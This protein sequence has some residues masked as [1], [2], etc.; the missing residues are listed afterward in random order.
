MC[1]MEN[2]SKLNNHVGLND[3]VGWKNALSLLI[4]QGKLGCGI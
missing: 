2:W 3:F 4:V 1:R